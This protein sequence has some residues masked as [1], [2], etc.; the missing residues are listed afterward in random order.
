VWVFVHAE[1]LSFKKTSRAAEQDRP[2][3]ARKR[4]RWKAH[5]NKIDAARLVFVDE[6]WVKTNMSPLR[7]WGPRSHASMQWCLRAPHPLLSESRPA[8]LLVAQ[9][10]APPD[11]A[12]FGMSAVAGVLV[13]HVLRHD[14]ERYTGRV[15]LSSADR[16][17]RGLI[18]ELR[19]HWALQSLSYARVTS[20][21][22]PSHRLCWT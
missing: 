7:G 15:L 8:I 13:M 3:V 22:S 20:R 14:S 1:G 2:D 9:R 17:W 10:R 12:A 4:R 18:A 19:S 11:W 21:C 5:Q 16:R 6:T